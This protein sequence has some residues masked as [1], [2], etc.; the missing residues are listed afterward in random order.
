MEV[1]ETP[2]QM[3][4]VMQIIR[5]EVI[6]VGIALTLEVE[7]VRGVVEKTP[8]V[9]RVIGEVTEVAVRLLSLGLDKLEAVVVV[10]LLVISEGPVMVLMEEVMDLSP[11]TQAMLLQEEE[12][13]V[14][15]K[16]SRA[17]ALVQVQGVG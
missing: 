2:L 4:L 12:L 9:V 7:L 3:E 13:A 16:Y 1:M 8:L 11:V 5:E 6:L 10:A 15:V 14:E 17:L